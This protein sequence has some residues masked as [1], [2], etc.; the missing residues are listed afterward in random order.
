METIA[1]TTVQSG[2]TQPI[3]P[4]ATPGLAPHHALANYLAIDTLLNGNQ[5]RSLKQL[6]GKPPCSDMSASEFIGALNALEAAGYL[7]LVLYKGK[8]LVVAND[9]AVQTHLSTMLHALVQPKTEV[10]SSMNGNIDASAAL[11]LTISDNGAQ[12]DD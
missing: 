11:P 5:A 10:N 3:A 8:R 7:T 4:L 9:L 2:G 12:N 1:P 6:H